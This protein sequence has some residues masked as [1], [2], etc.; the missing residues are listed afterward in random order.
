MSPFL[1]DLRERKLFWF[2][3]A[4]SLLL[5]SLIVSLK[6]LCLGT[7]YKIAAGDI[8]LLRE[9]IWPTL[10]YFCLLAA[11]F[12][13]TNIGLQFLSVS[14]ITI[15]GPFMH[16]EVL[17]KFTCVTSMESP[18]AIVILPFTYLMIFIISKWI[19]KISNSY[20]AAALFLAY[21]LMGSYFILAF[22]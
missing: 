17:R 22:L 6:F 5:F 12:F 3:A 4:G 2:I 14:I 10:F 1:M 11:P 20:L 21:A 19:S 15:L 16:L 18:L 7:E 9:V 13:I 8:T